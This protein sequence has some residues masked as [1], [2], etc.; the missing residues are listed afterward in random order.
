MI[1]NTKLNY[2]TTRHKTQHRTQKTSIAY[3]LPF[4]YSF[5]T[6]VRKKFLKVSGRL[7]RMKN[8]RLTICLTYKKTLIL[9]KKKRKH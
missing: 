9:H 2:Q 5:Q 8:N 7:F 4:I 1:K 6:L 3:H